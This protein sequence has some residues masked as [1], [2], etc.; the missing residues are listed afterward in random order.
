M[1][2]GLVHW[3]IAFVIALGLHGIALRE[4][5]STSGD[6]PA[7]ATATALDIDFVDTTD[8]PREPIEA[9]A[10]R[11]LDEPEPEPEPEPDS[12]PLPEPQ[13]PPQPKLPQPEPPPVIHSAH[14]L[15]A[16][17]KLRQTGRVPGVSSAEMAA[18]AADY[19]DKLLSRIER[20][21]RYPRRALLRRKQGKVKL[22][23]TIAADGGLL[24]ARVVSTSGHSVLDQAALRLAHDS[25]PFPSPPYGAQTPLEVIVPVA[26]RL[27]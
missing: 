21:K 1:K 13:P 18:H 8:T 26:Y 22:F 11:P 9:P 27:R 23:L 16:V 20:N 14:T 3:L 24:S 17:P 4:L 6:V 25:S 15:P 10:T 2:P 12:E 5:P 7:V 19:S